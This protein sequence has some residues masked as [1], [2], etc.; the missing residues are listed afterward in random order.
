MEDDNDDLTES[1][2][3]AFDRFQQDMHEDDDELKVTIPPNF[4]LLPAKIA[5]SQVSSNRPHARRMLVRAEWSS[6]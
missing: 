6:A 2:E 4:Q 3:N 5:A 1:H